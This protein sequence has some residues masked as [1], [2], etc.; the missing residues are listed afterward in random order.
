MSGSTANMANCDNAL[1]DLTEAGSDSGSSSPYGT[2]GR[3]GN[4][5]EWNEA[6]IS[7]SSRGTRGG[8]FK[9]GAAFLPGSHRNVLV[10]PTKGSGDRVSKPISV[11]PVPVPSPGPLAFTHLGTLM[12]AAGFRRPRA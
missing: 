7:V 8:G 10:G 5:F 9:N 12:G 1:A 6:I 11:L 2:F 4:A 3:G